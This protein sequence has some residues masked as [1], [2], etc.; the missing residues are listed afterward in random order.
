MIEGMYISASGMLPKAARQEA[1]AN[2]IANIGVPGYKRDSMFLR[3]KK[4][5]FQIHKYPPDIH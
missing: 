3:E 5:H 2:N 4:Y 1:V